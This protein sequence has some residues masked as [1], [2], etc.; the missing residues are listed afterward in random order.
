[1]S[2]C[3]DV[4]APSRGTTDIYVHL[5]EGILKDDPLNKPKIIIHEFL[6]SFGVDNVEAFGND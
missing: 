5:I 1:M 6:R 2:T 4:N 3:A